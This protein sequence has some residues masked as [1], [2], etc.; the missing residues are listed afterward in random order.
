MRRSVGCAALCSAI[1]ILAAACANRQPLVT[2]GPAR[3]ETVVTMTA[4]DFKFVPNNIKAHRGDVLLLEIENTSGGGHNFTIKDPQGR[5]LQSVTLPA[6]KTVTVKLVLSD[7]GTYEFYCDRPLHAAF[8]MK[9][10]IQAI[11]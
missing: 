2:I 5:P 3:G 7:D 6:K 8:G 9:G 11:Q 1:F 10:W 4:S